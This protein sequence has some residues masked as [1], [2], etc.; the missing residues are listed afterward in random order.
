MMVLKS[1]RGSGTRQIFDGLTKCPGSN[2]NLF[3]RQLDVAR[4]GL[5]ILRQ[6]LLILWNRE[7]KASVYE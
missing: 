2:S 6:M 1:L 7:V 4:K 5:N 3:V